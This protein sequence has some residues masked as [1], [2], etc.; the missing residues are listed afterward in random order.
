MLLGV[1]GRL[2][3]VWVY[4][5]VPQA[6]P[7]K[8]LHHAHWHVAM[9]PGK[10][11]ALNKENAADAMID[12]AGKLKASIRAKVEHP[13]RVIKRQFGFARVRYRGLKKNT[14]Q[15]V[16]LFALSNLCMARGK[17]MGVQA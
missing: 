11:R 4:S 16:T 12:K 1:G 3:A 15:L 8:A 14:V 13:F 9:G 5:C 6:P 7:K 2:N 10:R 17:L